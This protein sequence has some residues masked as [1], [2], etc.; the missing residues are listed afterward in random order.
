[1][2]PNP[3]TAPPRIPEPLSPDRER[4]CLRVLG[5][6]SRPVLS[7]R[8][9]ELLKR[10]LHSADWRPLP[11]LPSTRMIEPL[12]RHHAA[13][14][15][16][17][18][19]RLFAD[20]RSSRAATHSVANAPGVVPDLAAYRRQALLGEVLAAFRNAGIGPVVLIKGAA[21]APLYPTPALRLM[22][23]FDLVLPAGSRGPAASAV[24]RRLGWNRHL[25]DGSEVW[26][27]PSGLMI[28]IHIAES[29]FGR[30]AFDRAE[31]HPCFG[32]TPDSAHVLW[33]RPAHHLVLIALHTARNG[34]GRLW[35][36]VC[37]AQ[38]LLAHTAAPAAGMANTT[39][40]D[41]AL[42]IAARF[43]HAVQ[44]AAL[45]RFLNRW[46][47]P[48]F[49]LPEAIPDPAAGSGD[50]ERETR[51]HAILYRR[52][53]VEQIPPVALNL[54]QFTLRSPG[55]WIVRTGQAL[56]R[57]AKVPFSS[58]GRTRNEPKTTLLPG[59]KSRRRE[60]AEGDAWAE[61]D[62]EMGD[63]PARG[64]LARQALKL[65]LALR[66]VLSGRFPQYL[67]LVRLQGRVSRK[68]ARPFGTVKAP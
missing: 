6:L 42:S 56:T 14:T 1:M 60:D 8:H 32:D 67:R 47:L 20:D 62:P 37:D 36:D 31:P 16:I 59:R 61:R 7:S 5:I 50:C 10:E 34:G 52:Q 4:Q 55:E 51:L 48:P 65:R 63:L 57:A 58:A 12:F 44:V 25:Y 19:H 43:G 46:A 53:A 35:R 39:A 41:E 21:L 18:F 64:S 3:S 30:E 45:F 68:A 9:G 49:R 23:D 33:P 26:S 66:V 28:D 15:G 24:L 40:A 29:G 38:A 54:L 17:P 27:H 2:S 13:A 11:R 22:C